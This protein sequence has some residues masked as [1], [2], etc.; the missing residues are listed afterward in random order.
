[1]VPGPVSSLLAATC[2]DKAPVPLPLLMVRQ[3]LAGLGLD[4]LGVHQTTLDTTITAKEVD[5]GTGLAA[6]RDWVGL[7]DAETLAVG[8][9][10]PDLAMFRNSTRSFAP[11]HIGCARLVRL[12]GCRIDSQPYQRGLLSIVR[13]L[14][15]P[16][17]GS[18]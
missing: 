10:E 13:S 9:S 3:V 15:H 14:V 11:A 2:D 1:P 7:A 16:A 5:K 12:L 17:G 18:C 8:D 4:R 6:L